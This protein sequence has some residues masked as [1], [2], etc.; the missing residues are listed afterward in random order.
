MVLAGDY[1]KALS[2]IREKVDVFLLDPPYKD[3]LYEDCLKEIDTLDLLSSEG[4]I[5]AEHGIRDSVPERTG[6]LVKVRERKYGKIKV[7]IYRREDFLREEEPEMVD[8]REDVAEGELQ[9]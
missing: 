3:G 7:S 4:I 9:K 8:D 5:I 1:R 6:S 2:R